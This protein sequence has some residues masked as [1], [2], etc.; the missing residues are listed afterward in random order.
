MVQLYGFGLQLR[1]WHVGLQFR[2]NRMRFK[3]KLRDIN[4]QNLRSFASSIDFD[5]Y[6]IE[7][8]APTIFKLKDLVQGKT[9]QASQMFRCE[10]FGL[11][12][13]AQPVSID[14]F[15][16]RMRCHV[17]VAYAILCLVSL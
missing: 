6:R 9:A 17:V 13:F 3:K 5:L 1:H 11:T 7:P 10:A 12:Q 14:P 8:L 15:I 2:R 4:R 16:I